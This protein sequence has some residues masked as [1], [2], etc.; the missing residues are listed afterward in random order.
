MLWIVGGLAVALVVAALVWVVL[1][2]RDLRPLEEPHAYAAPAVTEPG[3]Q[4]RSGVTFGGSEPVDDTVVDETVPR[5][6]L[7]G[8]GWRDGGG[9]GAETTT[10]S[11]AASARTW[12]EPESD[13]ETVREPDAE[14]HVRVDD[15]GA[16]P[17]VGSA[18]DERRGG[19]W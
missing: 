3:R 16:R 5:S 18:E 14:H 12:A 19:H 6:R 15:A 7:G 8:A 11:Y 17:V 13:A 10:D 4:G 1:R 9:P 2:R